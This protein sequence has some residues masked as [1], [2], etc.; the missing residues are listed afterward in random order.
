MTDPR[1]FREYQDA[2]SPGLD[3]PGWA[4]PHR[5][6]S[7]RPAGFDRTVGHDIPPDVSFALRVDQGDACPGVPGEAESAPDRNVEPAT[8]D[9]RDGTNQGWGE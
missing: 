1:Y 8:Y 3:T 6:G 4:L 7:N 5:T 9:W 2:F